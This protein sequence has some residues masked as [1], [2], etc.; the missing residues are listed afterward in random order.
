MTLDHAW[1]KYEIMD[2]R[3]EIITST[4]LL[5]YRLL[6]TQGFRCI[7]R[8]CEEKNEFVLVDRVSLVLAEDGDL[9]TER[10]SGGNDIPYQ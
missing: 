4:R 6:F 9:V 2:D 10:S 8:R 1:E 5:L 7:E 3:N